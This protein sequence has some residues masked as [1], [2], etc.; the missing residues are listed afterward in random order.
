MSNKTPLFICLCAVWNHRQEWTENLMQCFLD[1]DY[2]GRAELYLIDDR[3]GHKTEQMHGLVN[4]ADRAIYHI[5]NIER[6]PFLMAKYD[7][8]ITEAEP[9]T[10]V[11]SHVC[12]MD[13]DDLYLPHFLSDHAKVLETEPWSYPSKVYSSYG[14]Q[15]RVEDSGGRFWA[16]SAY[17]LESLRAIGGYGSSV[18]PVFDQ[19]FLQ[20]MRDQFGGAP[21]GPDRPGYVYM[22]DMSFDDHCSGRMGAQDNSWYTDTP[23]TTISDGPLVPRHNEMH[24]QVMQMYKVFTGGYNA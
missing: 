2:E 19:Q 17:R 20:R 15:F 22:W 9:P 8:G 13:D 16:S 6:F 3:P 21:K 12:V 11:D 5:K 4:N 10:W 14:G 24:E 7:Y 18:L 1:Q 23:P